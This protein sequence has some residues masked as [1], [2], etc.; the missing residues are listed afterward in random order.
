MVECVLDD[1]MLY[2]VQIG[3]YCS[4]AHDVTLIIDMN[5][6]YHR[7]CQGN[8]PGILPKR[9]QYIQRKGNVTVMNDCWIGSHVTIMSGVTIGDGAVIAAG[10]VVTKDVPPYAIVG[11]SPARIIKYRFSPEQISAL[12]TIRW[13]NWSDT[14]IAACADALYGNDINQFISEHR[15][16]ADAETPSSVLEI[17]Y[18][19]KTE[20]SET[21]RLLY[22]P[23]FEQDYPTYLRVI[24]AF[25]NQYESSG[26]ELLLYIKKDEALEQ[27]LEVL[28][29]VFA[30]YE[31][32]NC[33]INLFVENLEDESPLFA[34]ADAYITNRSL[35]NIRYVD[36]AC[37]YQMPVISSVNLPVFS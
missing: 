37:R 17:P 26:Y 29:E 32:K 24:D 9:P 6:D 13:W 4:I 7:I 1:S 33:Y 23:D 21:K 8:L 2:Q 14:K 27:K 3:R 11:G 36:F 12:E 19:K 10:S 5:H 20:Y 25:A 34:Q 35:D 15:D 16:D 31:N 28:N 22:M 18:I 30:K